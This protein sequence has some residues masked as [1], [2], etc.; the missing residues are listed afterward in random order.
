MRA[1]PC[2]QRS[3]FILLGDYIDRDP[4]SRGVI[5]FLMNLQKWLQRNDSA[6]SRPQGY[7]SDDRVCFRAITLET[8]I[9]AIHQSGAVELARKLWA[10]YRD[11]ERV[12]HLA[13]AEYTQVD[14]SSECGLAS[15]IGSLFLAH[16]RDQ[17]FQRHRL[18]PP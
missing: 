8:V 16:S 18:K 12:F 13:M 7:R 11:L 17:G 15:R 2:A 14:P 10:R 1:D 5:E 3:K 6:P 4:D 9:D